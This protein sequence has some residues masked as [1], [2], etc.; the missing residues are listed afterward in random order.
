MIF[1]GIEK[2]GWVG[3]QLAEHHHD[4]EGEALDCS[5]YKS[6]LRTITASTKG[7]SY[8]GRKRRTRSISNL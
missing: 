5:P 2:L 1:G 8:F 7:R 3:P 6:I 4:P